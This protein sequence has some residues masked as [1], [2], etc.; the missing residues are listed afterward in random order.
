M[1]TLLLMTACGENKD[2]FIIE[3]TLNNLGGRPLYAI[4]ATGDR[5][6]TDTLRPDDGRIAMQGSSATCI[7]VQLYD[8]QM[9]PVMRFYL[10]NGDRI[11]IKGD[12]RLPQEIRMKG[13]GLNS[14]LW[15]LIHGNYETFATLLAERRNT[16]R[17][18]KYT[19]ALRTAE[20]NADSILIAYISRHKGS[21]LS[22]ALLVDYLLRSD[23]LL[24]CDS[25]WKTL[26]ANARL[27]HTVD[28]MDEL[29]ARY[30]LT[31]L[32][33]RLPY[34][35]YPDSTDSMTFVNPRN[36]DATL[37]YIWAAEDEPSATCYDRLAPYLQQYGD[38]DV[39]VVALSFD[40]DTALWH[41]RIDND[42]L[43]V[44][45]LWCEGA[46]NNRIMQR[47]AIDRLPVV[48]LGDS[49]GMLVLR[50]NDLPDADLNTLTDSLVSPR[51]FTP[52][53]PIIK[54]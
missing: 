23:N 40:R 43:P 45:H 54:P 24:L 39:Q 53:K 4:Y 8:S 34:L 14:D 49:A 38:D 3:G 2:A 42:T 48:M 44:I 50:T 7:P 22:S 30:A 10:Q 15:K 25:L 13:N 37:L 21:Q 26:D 9:Q 5:I 47:Y 12:A 32:N 35:R 1:A 20:A 31:D 51:A 19:A 27:P 33:I 41:R 36:K 29:T 6:V 11:E 28:I 46:Y 18:G 16:A 17:T 52:D